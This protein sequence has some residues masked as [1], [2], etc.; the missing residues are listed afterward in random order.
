MK[1]E[2]ETGGMR[3]Q[4]QGRLE[5]PEAGRGGKDPP[6]QPPEGAQPWDT[7]T[8]DVWSP[9]WGRMDVFGFKPQFVAVCHGRPRKLQPRAVPQRLILPIQTQRGIW[10]GTPLKT[11]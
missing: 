2:A 7:L 8:S 6:L 4:A 9:G 3:P 11:V 1:T 5:P 10:P